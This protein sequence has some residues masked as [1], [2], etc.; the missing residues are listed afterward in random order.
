[1]NSDNVKFKDHLKEFELVA[2]ELGY[3]IGALNVNLYL[4][5]NDIDRAFKSA[6]ENHKLDILFS[7]D[8]EA[9]EFEGYVHTWGNTEDMA[10]Q[11]A[12]YIRYVQKYG[13]YADIDVMLEQIGIFWDDYMCINYNLTYVLNDFEIAKDSYVGNIKTNGIN[14]NNELLNELSYSVSFEELKNV[15]EIIDERQFIN[16]YVVENSFYNGMSAML[17]RKTVS[18]ADEFY[19]LPTDILIALNDEEQ[20]I[21]V[22]GEYEAN[23]D[24]INQMKEVVDLGDVDKAINFL[25]ANGFKSN[26]KPII[27]GNGLVT[28]MN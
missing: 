18:I 11:K 26:A 27:M 19:N 12:V 24:T 3:E 22:F 14:M 7:G 10:M 9:M 5:W 17:L 2:N 1:M 13:A 6:W 20:S 15:S 28:I 16:Q 21:K 8:L 25:N 4:E 23:I